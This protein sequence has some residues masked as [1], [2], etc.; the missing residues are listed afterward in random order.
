MIKVYTHTL[1]NVSEMSIR[2]PHNTSYNALGIYLERYGIWNST[3]A[4]D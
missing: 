2:M 1:Y 4:G 3:S